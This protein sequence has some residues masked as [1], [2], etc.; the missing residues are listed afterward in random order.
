[1]TTAGFLLMASLLSPALVFAGAAALGLGNALVGAVIGV[2]QVERTTSAV[3]GRVLS[4]KTALLMIA[5]PVGIGLAGV[6]AEYGSPVMAGFSVAGVW[7]LV[8]LAVIVS[9]ALRDLDS[10]ELSDAQQ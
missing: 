8:L 7:I 10:K 1:M 5:A 9:R 6:S 2:L 3:L 4:V